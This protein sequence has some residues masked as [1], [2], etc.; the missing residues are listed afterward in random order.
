M[1]II[2]R[3]IF[4][5]LLVSFFGCSKKD[6]KDLTSIKSKELDLQMIDAYKDGLKE[7]EK[8]DPIYAA[9]KFNEAELLYPQSKWAP[10]SSL[11]AAY[12]YYSYFYLLS[13]FFMHSKNLIKIFLMIITPFI[14]P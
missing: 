8:G 2:I 12:T 3:I 1:K 10:R 4:I 14:L 13:Y 5:F 11:M 7:L 9:R 6:N